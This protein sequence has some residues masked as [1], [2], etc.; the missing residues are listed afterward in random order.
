MPFSEDTTGFLVIV[1]GFVELLFAGFVVEIGFVV[2]T[3]FVVFV[4]VF[5]FVL[6]DV[7]VAGF[8][9][10]DELLPLFELL[11]VVEEPL[12]DAIGLLPFC[13]GVRFLILASSACVISCPSTEEYPPQ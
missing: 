11:F 12:F 10:L 3:G 6:L 1:F 5:G 7:E 4:V 9:L 8:V 13:L 2:L